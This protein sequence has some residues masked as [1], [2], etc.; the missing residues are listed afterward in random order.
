MKCDLCGKSPQF[1]HNV[2]HSKRHTNRRWVPNIHPA[3]IT[4]DGKQ[5]QLKLCTR[6]LRTHY[7]GV[8]KLA[9]SPS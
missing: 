3:T 4:I 7:K 8:K 1:G 2:S 6:C 9:S 5:K